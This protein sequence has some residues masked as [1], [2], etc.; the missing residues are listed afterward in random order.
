MLASFSHLQAGV[1]TVAVSIIAI[2]E[3]IKLVVRR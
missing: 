1:T 2:V 3:V